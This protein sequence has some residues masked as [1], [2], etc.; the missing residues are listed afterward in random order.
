MTDWIKTLDDAQRKHIEDQKRRAVE[1]PFQVVLGFLVGQ[2]INCFVLHRLGK[3]WGLP[4]RRLHWWVLLQCF[5]RDPGYPYNLVWQVGSD[6]SSL[7]SVSP[8][9][10]AALLDDVRKAREAEAAKRG[11]QPRPRGEAP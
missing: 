1:H 5:G 4:L 11:D 6:R 3:R 10:I 7:S 2:I 9:R 8:A